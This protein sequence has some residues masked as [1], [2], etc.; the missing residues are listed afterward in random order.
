MIFLGAA[1]V[2][3]AMAFYFAVGA[4]VRR[5]SSSMNDRLA[6]FVARSGSEANPPTGGLG[7]AFGVPLKVGKAME[8]TFRRLGLYGLFEKWNDSEKIDGLLR[9]ADL[10]DLIAAKDF[11]LIRLGSAALLS[12]A[13]FPASASFGPPGALLSI[14]SALVGFKLPAIFLIGMAND[15]K[16]RVKRALLDAVDLL[17]VGVGAGMTIDRAMRVY[18]EK[19]DNPLADEFRRAFARLDVG[20]SRREA[21]LELSER[22]D[23]DGLKLLVSSVLQAEKLGTPLSMILADIS[24]DV[25]ERHRQ[26]VREASAKVPVKMIFP[27]AGL[28]LPALFIVLLGPVALQLFRG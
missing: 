12:A 27:L 10:D 14:A 22:T 3:T 20:K 17:A 15:R 7:I 26:S 8:S 21:L 9:R 28:I 16:S 25:K 2:S 1:S 24:R 11:V 23:V 13:T 19:F 4:L 18:A 6:K 5:N